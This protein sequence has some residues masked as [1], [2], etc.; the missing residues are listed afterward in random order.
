MSD[1]IPTIDWWASEIYVHDRYDELTLIKILVDAL[2]TEK[3]RL[4]IQTQI[5]PIEPIN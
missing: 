2:Y 4:G 1:I 3:Y 5:V